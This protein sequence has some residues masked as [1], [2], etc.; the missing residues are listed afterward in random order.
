MNKKRIVIGLLIFTSFLFGFRGKSI[1]G[2]YDLLCMSALFILG[3]GFALIIA[4]LDKQE[5]KILYKQKKK[6]KKTKKGK[7]KK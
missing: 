6:V 2:W 5:R 3:V 7:K 4:S 1:M